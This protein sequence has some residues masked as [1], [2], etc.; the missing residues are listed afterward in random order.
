MEDAFEGQ[1]GKGSHAEKED[2]LRTGGSR[3]RV[4]GEG[5][6]DCREKEV[7]AVEWGGKI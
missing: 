5:A 7:F 6:F 1:A 2:S 3:K 4:S